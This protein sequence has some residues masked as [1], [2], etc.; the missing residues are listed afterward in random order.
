M[1]EVI[2][3]RAQEIRQ[4]Y[5]EA[6][7]HKKDSVHLRDSERIHNK[8][9]LH[10]NPDDGWSH[11]VDRQWDKDAIRCRNEWRAAKIRGCWLQPRIPLSDEHAK[12]LLYL[13]KSLDRRTV[14]MK[15]GLDHSHW[16][17]FLIEKFRSMVDLLL[18]E[19]IHLLIHREDL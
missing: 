3:R 16:G 15:F 4:L 5:E 14:K 11:I 13:K 9:K 8:E 6:W 2:C 7:R 17:M 1:K 12:T 18:E 10:R 19:N